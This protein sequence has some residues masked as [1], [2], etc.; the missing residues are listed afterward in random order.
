MLR[1]RVREIAENQIADVYAFLHASERLDL[2]ADR[3]RALDAR[4]QRRHCNERSRV[5]R[6][7]RIFHFQK[8]S[9][10]QEFREHAADQRARSLPH[11][12]N[13]QR[14]QRPPL[15]IQRKR[16]K[17]Y[18][19]QRAQSPCAAPARRIR[20]ASSGLWH[21]D[22][23][24]ERASTRIVIQPIADV[25]FQRIQF[26]IPFKLSPEISYV[27]LFVLKE[28]IFS[29]SGIH[30]QKCMSLPIRRH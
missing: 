3:F 14:N 6:H 30:L 11:N 4:Q 22:F 24:R 16:H 17:Q 27:A 9:R 21:S 19:C 28:R 15:R 5:V 20:N 12:R 25:P 23:P 1:V 29:C 13:A 2:I 26:R 7:K 10:L 18:R 8:H